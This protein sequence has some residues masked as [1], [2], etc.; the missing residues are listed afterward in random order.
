ML[1]LLFDQWTDCPDYFG[2]LEPCFCFR[3]CGDVATKVDSDCQNQILKI[4]FLI[5][6]D[7]N[8]MQHCRVLNQECSYLLLNSFSLSGVCYLLLYCRSLIK[9]KTFCAKIFYAKC[10]KLSNGFIIWSMINLKTKS[11]YYYQILWY[12][13][14]LQQC[15]RSVRM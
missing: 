7:K 14:S 1:C 8:Y 5:Q 10:W 6:F 3:W 2:S 13:H 15:S 9:N 4:S 11:L 12:M